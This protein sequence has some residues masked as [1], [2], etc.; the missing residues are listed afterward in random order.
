MD[1]RKH[2]QRQ[3][4]WSR[5]NTS[6]ATQDLQVDAIKGVI[7]SVLVDMEDTTMADGLERSVYILIPKMGN[8]KE[9]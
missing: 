6:S 9:C 7:C 8:A 4:S 3:S 1:P 5:W 2:C